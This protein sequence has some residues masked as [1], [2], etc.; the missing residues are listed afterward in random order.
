MP[1]QSEAKLRVFSEG[2]LMNRQCQG[3]PPQREDSQLLKLTSIAM[4][5]HFDCPLIHWAIT[6]IY[7]VTICSGRVCTYSLV[8][9]FGLLDSLSAKSSLRLPM[10]WPVATP[11]VSSLLFLALS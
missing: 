10:F 6:N 4:T 3:H 1:W 9:T 5:E 7:L 8:T 2:I 11:P